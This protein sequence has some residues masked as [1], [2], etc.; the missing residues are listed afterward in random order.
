M[1]N[2]KISVLIVTYNSM[3]YILDCLKSVYQSKLEGFSLE[4]IISDNAS[5]D[6]TVNLITKNYGKSKIITNKNN[7]GFV[8]GIDIAI[9][10]ALDSNSD[11]F[12]ISRYSYKKRYYSKLIQI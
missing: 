5:K 2:L 11:Y 3:D 9:K 4:V 10:E 6:D 1:N 7:T 12:F 8:G